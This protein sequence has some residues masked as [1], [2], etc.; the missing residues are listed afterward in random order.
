MTVEEREQEQ[1]RLQ[2]VLGGLLR[3][4][5]ITAASVVVCG[6]CIYLFRHGFSH[7]DYHTFHGEPAR[8]R[9]LT[10]IVTD[11]ASL[12]GQAIIQ[13][14]L[15]LLIATPVVRVAFSAYAFARERDGKY[16]AITLIVLGLLLF[17]LFGT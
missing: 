8:F 14:G 15:L 6:A 10:G 13:M 11:V 7:P 2:Y 3:Y 12:R 17:S 9:S 16:V 5:V 4:G 1:I